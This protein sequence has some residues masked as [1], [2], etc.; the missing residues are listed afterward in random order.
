[1]KPLVVFDGECG[2]ALEQMQGILVSSRFDLGYTELFRFAAVMSGP[3]RLVTVFS[4]T[5]WSSIKEIKPPFMVDGEH[6]IVFKY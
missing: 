2:M 3:S 4:G 1:M 6:G 5:L